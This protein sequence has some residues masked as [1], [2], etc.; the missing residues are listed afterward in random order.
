MTD[1]GTIYN[2]GGFFSRKNREKWG[3]NGEESRNLSVKMAERG[4]FEPPVEFDPY[5][6]LANRSF[7]PLRHLS[8]SVQ[9]CFILY[10]AFETNSRRKAKKMRKWTMRRRWR[11]RKRQ[12]RAAI[13][14]FGVRLHAVSLARR[15]DPAFGYGRHSTGKNMPSV[16][17]FALRRKTRP[18]MPCFEYAGRPMKLTWCRISSGPNGPRRTSTR[19]NR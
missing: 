18:G 1:Y 10:S 2:S 3:R 4:G 7:R 5:D 6:G 12:G 15:S 16:A 11:G 19:S 17:A 8:A 9:I 13:V 14:R